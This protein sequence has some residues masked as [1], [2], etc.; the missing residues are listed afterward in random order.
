MSTLQP[1][2][3]RKARN[4]GGGCGPKVEGAPL[5]CW[6]EG[7]GRGQRDEV[8]RQM[9]ATPDPSGRRKGPYCAEPL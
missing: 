4:G 9:E 8:L 6:A 1:S 7:E 3:E 2:L 5:Y